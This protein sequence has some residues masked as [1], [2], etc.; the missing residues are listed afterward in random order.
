MN[1]ILLD[2]F[3]PEVSM[4]LDLGNNFLIYIKTGNYFGESALE[5]RDSHQLGRPD[6]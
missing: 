1:K 6:C 3:D 2:R 5:E 4:D